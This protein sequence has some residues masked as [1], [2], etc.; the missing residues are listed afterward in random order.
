MPGTWGEVSAALKFG[1]VD[2]TMVEPSLLA[3]GY[4]MRQLRRRWT[5][6]DL[7][8]HK[9]ALGGYNAGNGSIGRA[10]RAC[11]SPQTWDTLVPCLPGVTGRHS[12]E[13]IGYV[14]STWKWWKALTT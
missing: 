3:W 8:R 1:L 13:T 10:Y 9:F 11:N 4:Y 7:E 6:D 2:R 14:R 12:A 5:M